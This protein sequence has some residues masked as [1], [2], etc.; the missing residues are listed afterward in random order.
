MTKDQ[1]L[2]AIGGLLKTSERSGWR[3]S[4]DITAWRTLAASPSQG[5]IDIEG[6]QGSSNNDRLTHYLS[7]LMC[8]SRWNDGSLATGIVVR[9]TNQGFNGDAAGILNSLKSPDC[10][11]SKGLDKD[12]LQRLSNKVQNVN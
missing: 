4:D 7:R 12:L 1:V 3:N 5:S 10:Q 2:G 9:A 11:A 8:S 6:L